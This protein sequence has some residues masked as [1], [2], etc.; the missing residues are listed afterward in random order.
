M[1]ERVP[2]LRPRSRQVR[3][4]RLDDRQDVR[5]PLSPSP[6]TADLRSVMSVAARKVLP[7]AINAS[8]SSHRWRTRASNCSASVSLVAISARAMT[9]GREVLAERPT[10][11]FPASS[12]LGLISGRGSAPSTSSDEDARARAATRI[13]SD[14]LTAPVTSAKEIDARR[15]SRRSSQRSSR[16]APDENA[17]GILLRRRRVTGEG[18]KRNATGGPRRSFTSGK[19]PCG[20]LDVAITQER[21]CSLLA[22]RRGVRGIDPAFIRTRPADGGVIS[23]H[24]IADH[25]DIAVVA[26]IHLVVTPPTEHPVG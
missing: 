7:D 12:P 8:S 24:S 9:S 25:D 22:A 15:G 16:L 14:T 1:E 26:P 20:R 2:G 23:R 5:L 13:L 21:P 3:R 18:S 11:L 19:A 10:G 4:S 6:G 17:S